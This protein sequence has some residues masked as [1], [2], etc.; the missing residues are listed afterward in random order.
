MYL[1]QSNGWI[2]FGWYYYI[3]FRTT[4][5]VLISTKVYGYHPGNGNRYRDNN[6]T[7]N[8][9]YHLGNIL[10]VGIDDPSS[11]EGQIDVYLNL[12]SR[13]EWFC[14]LKFWCTIPIFIFFRFRYKFFNIRYR[15]F[16]F[17]FWFFTI[18]SRCLISILS[19]TI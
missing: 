13:F 17:L 11:W 5:K 6:V 15:L 1:L 18:V 12:I 9:R 8:A 2:F 10:P 19:P 14:K 16:V 3:Y 4:K 7:G